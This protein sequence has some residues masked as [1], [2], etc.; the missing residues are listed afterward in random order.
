MSNMIA[1]K[2]ARMR[3]ERSATGQIASYLAWMSAEGGDKGPEIVQQLEADL[4]ET[5]ST[6]A[7][8]RTLIM[9]EKAILLSSVANGVDDRA[10]RE[11]NAVRNFVL[12]LRRYVAHG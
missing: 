8:I 4:M 2:R 1:K 12:E 7:G 10:L 3:E 5:F 11:A 9:L 6:E